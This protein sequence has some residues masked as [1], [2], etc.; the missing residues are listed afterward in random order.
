MVLE[1]WIELEANPGFQ[2][3]ESPLEEIEAALAEG[4]IVL[5]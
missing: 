5:F 1:C 2:L 3:A 4:S